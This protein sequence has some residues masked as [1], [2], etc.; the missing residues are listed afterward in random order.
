MSQARAMV[1]REFNNPLVEANIEIPNLQEGQVLVEITAS[2]ICGSDI[3]MQQGKDP[4]TRLPIILGHEG[5]GIIRDIKGKRYDLYGSEL[6][7]G[8]TVIWSRGISCGHCYYCSV[9]REPSLCRERWV[10][11][12]HTCSDD[13]PYLNGCFADHLILSADTDIITVNPEWHLAPEV[14]V[15]ASCSGATIAHAFELAGAIQGDTVLVQGPGPLGIYGVAFAKSM[16]ASKVIVIGGSKNRLEMC[17]KFGADII[18]NRRDTPPEDRTDV[19]MDI[20]GGLGVDLVIEAAGD[21][22]AVKE[23]ISL[24]R[25]GAKYLSAGFGVPVGPMEFDC[26]HDLVRKNL[27]L[28][29]VWVSDTKHMVMAVNLLKSIG[30]TAKEMISHR[31]PLDQANEALNAAKSK[32]AVKVILVNKG[33]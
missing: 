16:G 13:Y 32:D 10:Y 33:E 5:V 1:L 18:L 12:I 9:L 6:S 24:A 26:Y 17:R 30:G 7:P 15:S 4:R 27:H 14:L 3:H 23:G 20:T 19:I 28:Q 11:G 29:G 21:P 31:F 25:T 22:G 8:M 2:G